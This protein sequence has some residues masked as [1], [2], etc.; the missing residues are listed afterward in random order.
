MLVTKLVRNQCQKHDVRNR[1]R[2]RERGNNEDD[3]NNTD[4]L[5]SKH[6]KRKLKTTE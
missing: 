4:K 2:E 1:V 3:R 6:E 5:T